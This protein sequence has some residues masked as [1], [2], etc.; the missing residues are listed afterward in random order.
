LCCVEQLGEAK[1]NAM[2]MTNENLRWA[3]RKVAALL[4]KLAHEMRAEALIALEAA[5]R[6]E[7]RR[8]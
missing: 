2:P 6:L 1:L 5:M 3:R 8:A 7:G 4:L